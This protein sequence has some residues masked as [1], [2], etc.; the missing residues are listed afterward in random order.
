[1]RALDAVF[2][3][4]VCAELLGGSGSVNVREEH[5]D[6]EGIQDGDVRDPAGDGFHPEV[7][8]TGA[9]DK[10]DVGELGQW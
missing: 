7:G 1:M 2:G 8:L 5:G 6:V 9:G 4:G 10:G 3:E